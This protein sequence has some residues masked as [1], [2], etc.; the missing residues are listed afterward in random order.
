MPIGEVGYRPKENTDPE[1]N[2]KNVLKNI[3]GST[4]QTDQ[5][6]LTSLLYGNTFRG[7]SSTSTNELSDL[8]YLGGGLG[9]AAIKK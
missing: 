2:K 7:L 9:G 3:L 6:D 1:S 5:D 4:Q 8:S